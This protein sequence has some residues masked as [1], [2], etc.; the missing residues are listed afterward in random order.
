MFESVDA[1]THGR[2]HGRRLESHPIS[3][4]CE[5]SAQVS[6]KG[7]IFKRVI[8]VLFRYFK[9]SPYLSSLPFYE[10]RMASKMAAK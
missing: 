2:T 5:P 7:K 3:S 8:L 6:I 9:R 4:P 10:S 1:R